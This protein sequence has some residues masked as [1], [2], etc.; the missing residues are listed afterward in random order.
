M[1]LLYFVV[2][3]ALVA[4]MSAGTL[5]IF[6]GNVIDSPSNQHRDGWIFVQSA[7]GMLREVDVSKAQVTYSEDVPPGQRAK[8][9]NADLV[10]GSEVT[11]TAEQDN[12]GEWH[13]REVEIIRLSSQ[14]ASK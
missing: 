6:R 3:L 7:K 14:R 1:R 11:V 8:S 9:P 13:A 10:P 5:G 12:G 2:P 4:A